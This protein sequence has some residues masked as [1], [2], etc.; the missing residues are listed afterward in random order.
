MI[1]EMTASALLA[2]AP[3]PTRASGETAQYI[4]AQY[5]KPRR[6]LRSSH[7]LGRGMQAAAEELRRVADESS[8]A[9]WDCYGAAPVTN[10]TY[11]QAQCFLEA[12]PLGTPAPSVG[13][14]PDGHLTLE[15]HH[16]LRRTLS[17]SISPEGDVHYSALIGPSKMYGTEPFLGEVSQAVI[18]LINR[19]K[20]EPAL[21][22][23]FAA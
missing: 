17:V 10:D 3:V 18:D 19:I 22:P 14:E 15:W 5:G 4:A 21:A 23:L 1:L 11:V 2:V 9:N 8:R 7:S 6:R 16:S 13:A 12:L 20:P